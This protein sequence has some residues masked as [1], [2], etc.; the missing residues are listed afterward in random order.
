V[1]EEDFGVGGC[2][3][4][5][6]VQSWRIEGGVARPLDRFEVERDRS[7]QLA[8]SAHYF[9]HSDGLLATAYYEQGV[10]FVDSS[11]PARL[12]QVGWWVPRRSMVFAALFAP[13][14]PS[15]SVVYAIDHVRGIQV[16]QVDRSALA[17]RRRRA[18]RRPRARDV[19]LYVTDRHDRVRRGQ[20]LRFSVEAI[21]VA[22]RPGGAS[23]R[24]K[25]PRAL[26]GIRTGRGAR[27][28]RRT[29]TLS[30]R[31]RRLRDVAVR[32]FSA[33]VRRGARLGSEIAVVGYARG[34]GDQLLLDDRG[35]DVS[36]VGRRARRL[37]GSAAASVAGGR[38]AVPPGVCL[39]PPARPP[40]RK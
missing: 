16:L 37:R 8:C 26:T 30:F 31:V 21:R 7:A 2:R 38:P 27:F 40:L 13:T 25:V 24:L 20:R 12:T 34:R 3:R 22:G 35:V 1:T 19:G 6:S 4:S 10:R 5:G 36:R 17:P 23:V 15:G 33:R 9:D 29:R 18:G 28:S 14:D 39:I 11:D 32:G